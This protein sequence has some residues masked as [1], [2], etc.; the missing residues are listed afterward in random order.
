MK[1]YYLPTKT[2]KGPNPKPSEMDVRPMS[3]EYNGK[4]GQRLMQVEINGK[5]Q[6]VRWNEKTKTWQ[7][8]TF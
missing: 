7:K 5:I 6:E 1:I 4:K 8:G 2:K 3:L